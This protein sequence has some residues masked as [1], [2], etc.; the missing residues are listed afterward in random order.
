M[1][2]RQLIAI[3]YPGRRDSGR[4]LDLRLEEH[5]FDVRYP[6]QLRSPDEPDAGPHTAAL[7]KA[8]GAEPDRLAGILGYCMAGHL[9]QE[10]AGRL[11]ADHGVVLPV[12]LVDSTPCTAAAVAEECRAVFEVFGPDAGG[13]LPG[14]GAL[15]ALLD[16]GTLRDRPSYVIATLRD[17]MLRRVMETLAEDGAEERELKEAAAPVVDHYVAWLTHL[18][19][20]HNCTAPAWGGEVLHLVSRDHP[21]RADWPGSAATRTEAVD[22]DRAGLPGT[23]RARETVLAFLRDTTGR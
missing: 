2:D 11:A 14:P 3:D 12:V 10:V 4:L 6:I 1:A 19:A 13:P 22:A 8:S 18:V 9:A 16:P 20:A 21:F 15:E 17:A 23:A 7:I 5:G